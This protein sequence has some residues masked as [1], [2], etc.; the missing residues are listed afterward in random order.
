MSDADID[1]ILGSGSSR[2]RWLL[3]PAAAIVVAA[4]VVVAFWLTGLTGSDSSEVVTEPQRAEAV[5]GRLSTE[6][7]LSGSAL[8]ERGDTLSFEVSGVVASV[9]ASQGDEVRRGLRSPLLMTPM[10]SA[11]S[12]Q[13]KY[14]C[15]R[16]SCAWTVC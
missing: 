6:V 10:R 1:S 14:D 9:T 4:A 16:R 3:L 7:E 15:A 2:R 13:P 12:R 11:G 5:M 8:S